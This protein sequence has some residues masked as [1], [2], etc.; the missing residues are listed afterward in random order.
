MR[1]L[2]DLSKIGVLLIGIALLAIAAIAVHFYITYVIPQ[3]LRVGAPD[4]FYAYCS[5]K[6][7][8]VHANREISDVMVLDN[9]SSQVCF[10]GRIPAGSDELCPV[11]DYGVYIVQGGEYKRVV[12][13]VEVR[14]IA[15]D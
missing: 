1:E 11:K 4:P 9:R 6:N 5:H 13:C 3:M 8:I 7:V 2:R 15:L 10:F 14:A 12:E